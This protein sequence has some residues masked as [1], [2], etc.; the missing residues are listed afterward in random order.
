MRDSIYLVR[1]QL[2]TV[3]LS[4]CLSL[5]AIALDATAADYRVELLV[6]A[7]LQRDDGTEHWPVPRSL[8][9][10][11]HALTLGTNGTRLLDGSRSLQASADALRRS[12]NY[13]V[14]LHWNWQQ[15]GW[16]P[17]Q[18]QPIQVQIPPGST[19]P[20]VTLPGELSKLAMQHLRDSLTA[21][22]PSLSAQSPLLDGTVN[23]IAGEVLQLDV[24]L[25]YRDP[26][27]GVPLQL[28]ESRRLHGGQLNY[29]D[30]P[31]FGV[32]TR[33]DPIAAAP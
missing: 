14:L 16:A 10:T 5:S 11:E 4:A 30:H 22:T 24:D 12:G 33:V 32:L 29:L 27:T 28:K 25:I 2:K 1:R 13:R 21:A 20:V 19:L 17:G 18:G 3:L 9:D 15:P 31:R 26:S 7:N 23:L 6:Y 8:P